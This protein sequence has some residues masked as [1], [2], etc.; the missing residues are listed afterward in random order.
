MFTLQ[1][2]RARSPRRP[3][4]TLSNALFA[5][6]FATFSTVG[7]AQITNG[8]GSERQEGRQSDS[9]SRTEPSGNVMQESNKPQS[10]DAAQGRSAKPAK[11]QKAD[12]GGGFGNG[13]YGT[14][15][16]SNK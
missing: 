15:A 3:S 13:L 7:V 11:D 9:S 10:K 6:L 4:S 8:S 5:G 2:D 1:F 12:G 14:G 16:G